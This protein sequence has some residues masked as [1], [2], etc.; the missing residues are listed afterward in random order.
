MSN[1]DPLNSPL[2]VIPRDIVAQWLVVAVTAEQEL[3]TGTKV[4]TAAYS[5][6]DGSRTVSYSAADLK[7]LRARIAELSAFLGIGRP[8]RHGPMRV[9]F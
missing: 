3:V 4:V 2:Q 5:Q 1:Y 6:G 7:Q 8:G 9:M